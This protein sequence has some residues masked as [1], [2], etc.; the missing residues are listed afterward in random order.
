MTGTNEPS[1]LGGDIKAAQGAVKE[2]IGHLIGHERMEA[3]GAAKRAEGNIEH[4]A[5]QTK[6]YAEGASDGVLGGIKKNAGKIL[7]N[8]TMEAEG[9]SREAKGDVKKAINS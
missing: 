4:D 3:S 7:G 5:A 6:Q 1:K 8:H 9:A 2:K